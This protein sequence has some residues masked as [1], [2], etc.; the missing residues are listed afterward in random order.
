MDIDA[1]EMISAGKRRS[2]Y[3][4]SV[5]FLCAMLMLFAVCLVQAADGQ[6]LITQ[7]CLGCHGIEKNCE[8][9]TNDPDWWKETVLRMVEYK[10]DLLSDDEADQIALFLAD[11]QQRATLCSAN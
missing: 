11:E 6:S 7:R 3:G 10:S 2:P 5:A 1:S 8:V 9:A 4:V